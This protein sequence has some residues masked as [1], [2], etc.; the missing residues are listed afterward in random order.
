MCYSGTLLNCLSQWLD[1]CLQTLKPHIAS[2]I[3]VCSLLLERITKPGTLMP[4]SYLFTAD[5]DSMYT[6][7]DTKHAL[8]VIGIWLDSLDLPDSFPLE[9]VKEA[10]KLVI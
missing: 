6:N 9:A 1:Y 5:A 10:M 2:H 8:E 7:I 4:D 3:K